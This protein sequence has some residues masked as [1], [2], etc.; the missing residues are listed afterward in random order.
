MPH[1]FRLTLPRVAPDAEAVAAALVEHGACLID[2]LPGI[3]A[4]H[5]LRQ[6]ACRLSAEGALH[7]AGIGRGGAHQLR[8]D[9]RGDSTLWLDDPRCG[10][11]ATLHLAALDGLRGDLNRLL[12]LGLSHTEAHYAIYPPGSRYARHRDRFRDSDA[13]VISVVSYLN[14]AW[15]ADDGGALRLYGDDGSAADILPTN[16]HSV[17]FLSELEHE[18]LP[19]RRERISIAAWLR[20]T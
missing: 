7:A 12:Y 17:C 19:A 20:R 16:A 6:E 3:E 1:S 14:E 13:R 8:G 10:L 5:Q 2:G 18:V 9:V 4:S 11:A 15:Q